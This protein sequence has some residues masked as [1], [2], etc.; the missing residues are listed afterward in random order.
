MA[1]SETSSPPAARIVIAGAGI[2]GLVLA[3]AIDKQVG[4]KAEVYEQAQAFTDGAGGAI[5]LYPNGLRVLRD[6]SPELLEAI[7][8]AGYPYLYRR[9]MKHDGSEVA[10]AKESVLSDDEA[11][12]SIG[13]RRW[14]LQRALFD[15]AVAAG[16][17]VEFAKH[18]ASVARRDDG[19]VECTFH[20]GTTR[21][22]ELMFGADG[23]KSK[24]R[25]AVVSQQNPEYTGVTCLMGAAKVKRP[26]RG[27]CFPSSSTTKCHACYYPTADDEQIFQIYFPSPENVETWGTLSPEEGKKECLELAEKLRADGWD[28]NF[29]QPLIEAEGVIRVGLRARD[30]LDKW[31]DGNIV[32]LGDAAHPPVP[33][34][35]QGAMMAVE[36]AGVIALLLRHHCLQDGE[37]KTENFGIAM[38][39][40]TE[41]RIPRTRKILGASKT[42]GATQQNR[43]DSWLYN[44]MREWTIRLQVL[45]YGTLPIMYPGATYDYSKDVANQL[46][47][48]SS[49]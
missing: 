27:I 31:V 33:Y 40:Y 22:T 9:W 28:D 24:V 36:D 6:T 42:L 17:K 34:I 12:Q 30:P 3:L 49:S 45:V 16:I 41:M 15:A 19:L 25:E 1:S 4:V 23:V 46:A 43:A 39:T 47:T 10:C 7:R 38:Q 32:L 18:I 20:D 21:V 37:F 29:L 48:T 8:T 14:K 5:G 11:L 13:I 35:G 26:Y 2:A 44:L